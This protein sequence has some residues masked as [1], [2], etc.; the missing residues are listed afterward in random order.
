MKELCEPVVSFRVLVI[1]EDPTNN[2]YTLMPLAR[3]LLKDVGKP[4]ARVQLPAV[5]IHGYDQAVRAIRG[6]LAG[7]YGREDLWLFCPDADRAGSDAML[8]LEGDLKERQIRLLCCAAQPEVEIFACVAF[9]DELKE[10]WERV[11][12]HPRMKEEVFEPLLKTRSTGGR[13]GGG[14]KS[15]MEASLRNL[16]LVYQLCPE[17]KRL[18]DRIADSVTGR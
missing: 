12:A 9:R 10:P 5:P 2:G 18:R 15:M 13:A 3:A 6:E 4:N 14:R 17:V 8:R 1:P 7:R 16:P 11:R